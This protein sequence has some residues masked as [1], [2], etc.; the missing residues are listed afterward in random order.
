MIEINIDEAP[1][2]ALLDRLTVKGSDMSGAF[3]AIAG[4]MLDAV[5]ENFE[6]EGRPPWPQNEKNGKKLADSTIAQREKKGHW[7]GKVLQVSG[8]LAASVTASY[9]PFAAIVGTNK[10]YAAIHQFGGQAGRGHK[11]TIPARPFLRLGEDDVED[12]LAIINR[13]L[14]AP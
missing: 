3:M 6:Q 1:V 2:L 7:P 10:I 4:V 13:Y 11:V 9:G 12:V 5:E 8:Q 14:L